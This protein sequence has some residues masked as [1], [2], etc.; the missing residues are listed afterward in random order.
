MNFYQLVLCIELHCNK[1]TETLGCGGKL[2]KQV[3]N[4]MKDLVIH[5]IATI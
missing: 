5:A 3:C 4:E 1:L 2:Q